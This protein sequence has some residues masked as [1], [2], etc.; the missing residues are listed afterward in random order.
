MADGEFYGM[1]SFD[2]SLFALYRDGWVSL[3]DAMAA[4]TSS[5]DLR[6]ALQRAGLVSTRSKAAAS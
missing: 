4:A 3:R 2:Q 5:H 1:Q 6:V